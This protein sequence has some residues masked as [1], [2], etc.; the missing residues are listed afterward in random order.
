MESKVAVCSTICAS[1]LFRI[2]ISKIF[3]VRNAFKPVGIVV[4]KYRVI[5]LTFCLSN[6]GY[7]RLVLGRL[8]CFIHSFFPSIKTFLLCFDLLNERFIGR[9]DCVLGFNTSDRRFQYGGL[10]HR[11]FKFNPINPDGRRGA[12]PVFPLVTVKFP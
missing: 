2:A 10:C 9:V 12:V 3:W 11:S 6:F 8:C 5:D 4:K 7:D 1:N